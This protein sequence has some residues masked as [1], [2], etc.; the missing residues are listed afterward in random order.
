MHILVDTAELLLA[1]LRPGHGLVD[2]AYIPIPYGASSSNRGGEPVIPGQRNRKEPINHDRERNIVERGIGCARQCPGHALREDRS[3]YL[4]LVLF[5]V[6]C[7]WRQKGFA[8]NGHT[9]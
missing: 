2:R 6:G 7:H 4:G 1:G 8:A 5:V 3:R 9:P